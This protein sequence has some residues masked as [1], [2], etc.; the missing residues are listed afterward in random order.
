MDKELP[1][2]VDEK[3][4]ISMLPTAEHED[5]PFQLTYYQWVPIILAFMIGVYALP[6]TPYWLDGV[7]IDNRKVDRRWVEGVKRGRQGREVGRRGRRVEEGGR[8]GGHAGRAGREERQA[9]E[10]GR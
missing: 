1:V 8:E 4:D 10:V 9:G 3:G 6:G 5:K 7:M 2:R